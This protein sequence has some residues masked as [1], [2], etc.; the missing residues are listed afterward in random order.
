MHRRPPAG[1]FFFSRRCTLKKSRRVTNE[2]EEVAAAA[3]ILPSHS[4]RTGKLV[5]PA[6]P[7][8]FGNFS[9]SPCARKKKVLSSENVTKRETRRKNYIFFMVIERQGRRGRDVTLV[10]KGGWCFLLWR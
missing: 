6:E 3:M 10:A 5:M 8:S 1:V 9:I 2:K 4:R 7:V